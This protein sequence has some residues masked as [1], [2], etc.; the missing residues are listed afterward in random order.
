M[1]PT[2]Q[3]SENDASSPLPNRTWVHVQS[4]NLDWI[5]YDYDIQQLKV[6]FVG[7]NVYG[8]AGVPKEKVIAMLLASSKGSY[9]YHNI[10]TAY[11][12][13]LHQ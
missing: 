1:I 9:F 3:V 13:G 4:S 11:P 5:W 12:Y 7:G 10:R 6:Q 2:A 8:Y